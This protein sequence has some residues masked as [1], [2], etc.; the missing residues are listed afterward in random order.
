MPSKSKSQQAYMAIQLEKKRAG[1]KTDV[2]MSKAQLSDFA[3]TKTTKL[4]QKV[5]PR[6]GSKSS[7]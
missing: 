5:K 1:K 3:S 2:E 7:Y 6:K 4:P